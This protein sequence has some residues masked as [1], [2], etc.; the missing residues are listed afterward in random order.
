MKIILVAALLIILASVCRAEDAVYFPTHEWRTSSPEAQGINSRC[1]IHLLAAIQQERLDVHSLLVVRHGYLV[2]EAYFYPF[3]RGYNHDIASVTKSITSTLIGIAMDQGRIRNTDELLVSFFPDLTIRNLDQRKKNIRLDDLLTMR[4][5]FKNNN[6]D[7]LVGLFT[8]PDFCQY[9]IDLP[10]SDKPGVRFNYTSC[11]THLLSCIL[12]RVTGQSARDFA[13]RYLF[14]PMGISQF[15]MPSDAQGVSYGWGD[16]HLLPVDMAKL[17]YLFLHKGRWGDKQ[18]LSSQWV[19]NATSMKVRL[20]ANG[21]SGYGYG[22]WI[23]EGGKTYA[24]I[25]RNGQR[26]I[27]IPE[28]DAVLVMNGSLGEKQC[29]RVTFLLNELLRPAVTNEGCLPEDT[30]TQKELAEML[31]AI[32]QPQKPW[33]QAGQAS[34]LGAMISG[35]TYHFSQNPLGLESF[36]LSLPDTKQ[37]RIALQIGKEKLDLPI[38]LNGEYIIVESDILTVPQD[39]TMRPPFAVKGKW[40]AEDTFVLNINEI[41]NINNLTVTTKFT[42]NNARMEIKDTHLDWFCFQLT[43]KVE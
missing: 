37:G 8:Q 5:G 2:L 42:G 4:A 23:L 22:W 39:T 32:T 11:A 9:C 41:S 20:S 17:G 40:I 31:V 13:R 24:A 29:E 1:I 3:R 34:P 6:D 10:M 43:A 25:G 14:E 15:G 7:T 28:M 30:T 26:I 16:M 33:E 21:D 27:V 35:K 38:G 12:S 36:C 18:L 19:E